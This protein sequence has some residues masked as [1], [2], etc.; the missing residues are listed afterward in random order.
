M[1]L[2]LAIMP[3]SLAS[4]Y[5]HLVFSTKDRVPFMVDRTVR[6]QVHAELNAI[7]GRLDCP[8]VSI[9]GV[10]D[11]VHLLLRMGRTVS[12]AQCVQE[13]KRVSSIDAKKISP[14]LRDFG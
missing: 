5:V 12:V 2:S 9:G 1:L 11:H 14:S 3:Q 4:L 10:G 7:A 8:T 13:L 6:K